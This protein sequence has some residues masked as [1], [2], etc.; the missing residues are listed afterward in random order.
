MNIEKLH[1][2]LIAKN[3]TIS[4]AESCT[5]GLLSTKLTELNGSSKY[6]NMGLITYSNLAKIKCLKVKKNIIDKLLIS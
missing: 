2:K 4:V 1:K 5:G 3:L 6:F